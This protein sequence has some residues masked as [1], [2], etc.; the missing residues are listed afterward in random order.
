MERHFYLTVRPYAKNDLT[1]SSE[2]IFIFWN[3]SKWIYFSAFWIMK[4]NKL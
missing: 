2:I 1:K 3:L 4:L